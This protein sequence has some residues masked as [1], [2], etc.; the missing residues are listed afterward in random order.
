[1]FVHGHP[2][3]YR[4]PRSYCHK[5]NLRARVDEPLERSRAVLSVFADGLKGGTSSKCHSE[6]RQY[7]VGDLQNSRKDIDGD[8]SQTSAGNEDL[9]SLGSTYSQMK[10]LLRRKKYDDVRE[11][12]DQTEGLHPA[13]DT[14]IWDVRIRCEGALYGAEAADKFFSSGVAWGLRPRY[15]NLAYLM[16]MYHHAKNY[17]MV[18][19][20]FRR[21]LKSGFTPDVYAYNILLNAKG[22][23]GDY[24]QCWRQFRRM[25]DTEQ[26]MYNEWTFSTM[27]RIAVLSGD[28]DQVKELEGIMA[29]IHVKTTTEFFN[30]MIDAHCK[31]GQAGHAERVLQ[32]IRKSGLRPDAYSFAPLLKIY[33]VR[34]DVAKLKSIYTWMAL[35]RCSPT[36]VLYNQLVGFFASKGDLQAVKNMLQTMQ[37]DDLRPNERSYVSAFRGFLK[38]GNGS[39]AK[40]LFEQM[41]ADGVQ[42]NSYV[43]SS[44]IGA[45]A[46]SSEPILSG[47]MA[48]ILS[49]TKMSPQRE[50]YNSVLYAHACC[51]DCNGMEEAF[52]K[53]RADCVEPDVVSFNILIYGCSKNGE[54]SRALKWL[55][56][57]IRHGTT[58]DSWTMTA[59]LTMLSA[60]KLQLITKD[61]LIKFCERN[62]I[63]TNVELW[64]TLIAALC[65]CG[66]VSEACQVLS[67][68]E[69]GQL[70]APNIQT[71][72]TLMDGFKKTGNSR[73]VEQV[74]KRMLAYGVLPG[75]HAVQILMKS[76]THRGEQFKI[77]ALLEDVKRL[78]VPVDQVLLSDVFDYHCRNKDIFE[79]VDVLRQMKLHKLVP[80]AKFCSTILMMCAKARFELTEDI[81]RIM[82]SLG[83]RISPEALGAFT[84]YCLSELNSDVA[85]VLREIESKNSSRPQDS[86]SRFDNFREL[87]N[88]FELG[89]EH[90]A[91]LRVHNLLF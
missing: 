47:Q 44:L 27:A 90:C 77:R 17:E 16:K 65:K 23:L 67:S 84:N 75:P 63:V 76:Y 38:D 74:Y 29:S 86:K 32:R 55:K 41:L 58:P 3:T 6:R 64:T 10:F 36:T 22:M 2:S 21:L 35:S 85:S 8:L 43:L 7:S 88:L 5:C 59:V 61:S 72:T 39:A 14:D 20:T 60:D 42:G 89:L 53:M 40:E 9:Q 66:R 52:R 51:S 71:Y 62:H 13:F 18:Q 46:K 11:L 91:S 54:P 70:E 57:M 87:Y 30:N 69:S 45:C 83:V 28:D 73:G 26:N 19:A 1:M 49:R 50:I 37:K 24:V 80:S 56:L 68:M 15:R 33:L 34:E 12:F 31:L 4:R 78:D 25:I 48:E 81:A 79:C 82:G